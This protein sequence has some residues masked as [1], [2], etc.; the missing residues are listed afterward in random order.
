MQRTELGSF[1]FSQEKEF[2]VTYCCKTTPKLNA[3]KQQQS[4]II[5]HRFSRSGNHKWLGWVV[6]SWGFLMRL[7]TV[8]TWGCSH[9]KAWLGLEDSL[10]RWLTHAVCEVVLSSW[11][12]STW[13]SPWDCLSIPAALWLASRISNAGVQGRSCN[14]VCD[15][16]S[17]FIL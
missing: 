3:L 13:D 8:V 7:Q 14:A 6:L 11:F 15:L 4:F 2:V 1:Y 17:G 12:F 16:A 10:P 5:S 9:V